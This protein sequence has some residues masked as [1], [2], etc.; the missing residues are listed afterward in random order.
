MK[1]VVRHEDFLKLIGENIRR[2][3][4][5]KGFSQR[6]LSDMTNTG[7][8]QLGRIE[9][10]EVNPRVSTLYEFALILEVDVKEFFLKQKL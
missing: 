9:R 2:I 8:N 3:R 6:E 10:G 5:A 1:E 4:E 7:K